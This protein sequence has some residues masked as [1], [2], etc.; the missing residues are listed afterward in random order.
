MENRANE[1]VSFKVGYLCGEPIQYVSRKSDEKVAKAIEMLNEL[2]FSENKANK[3]REIVE[4]QMICGTAYRAC[5]PDPSE[6][7]DAPF[8]IYSLDPRYT[9]VVYSSDVDHRPLMSCSYVVNELN[10]ITK[11]TC[12][13]NT[14]HFCLK[15]LFDLLF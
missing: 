12:Y 7:V 13:I 1:I 3:D 4:W 5:L 15:F 6:I 8:N 10:Q 2:M 14:S 9:F 11:M